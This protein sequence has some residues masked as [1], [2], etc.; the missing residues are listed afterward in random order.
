MNRFFVLLMGVIALITNPPVGD[1][2]K[3]MV[4]EIN[5]QWVT[6]YNA[7]QLERLIDFYRDDTVLMLSGHQPI[8][9]REGVRKFYAEDIKSTST[10]SMA[11]TSFRVEQSGDL[12]VDSGKWT[13]SG[14]LID[15]TAIRTTGNYVTV[16]KKTK[17]AWRTAID[18]SNVGQM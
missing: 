7:G 12:L 17:G 11:V 5:Q 16:M 10:R 4:E 8:L 13:F 6:A 15:G 3:S 9:G 1:N 18:I 14:V 2:A